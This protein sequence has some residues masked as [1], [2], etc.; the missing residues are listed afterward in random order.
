MRLFLFSI[1][2]LFFSINTHAL[3]P[4]SKLGK[5]YGRFSVRTAVRIGMPVTAGCFKSFNPLALELRS[6]KKPKDDEILEVEQLISELENSEVLLVFNEIDDKIYSQTVKVEIINGDKRSFFKRTVFSMEDAKKI[7]NAV[8]R[9]KKDQSLSEEKKKEER[10]ILRNAGYTMRTAEFL[11]KFSGSQQ[12][13]RPE[14]TQFSR[15]GE[16]TKTSA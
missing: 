9:L 4:V 8:N 6:G 1:F 11:E 10:E 7:K 5:L 3:A 15:F 16:F 13:G 14:P 2:F 12:K